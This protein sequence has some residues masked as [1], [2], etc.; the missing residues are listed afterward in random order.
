V[1][2]RFFA[3]VVLLNIV[4]YVIGFLVEPWIIFPGLF[5]AME[6]NSAYF[7]TSYHTVDWVTSYLYNFGVWL[8]PAWVHHLARPVLKGTDVIASLKVFGILLL[9]FAA[10]SAV[11][12]NHYSHPKDF[13]LWNLLDAVLMFAVVGVANGLLYRRVMG[14]FARESN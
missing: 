5:G 1:I 14:P 2:L 9:N 12:M 4:R 3:L 11:Y 13:Y 6:E 10:I 8:V 7:N